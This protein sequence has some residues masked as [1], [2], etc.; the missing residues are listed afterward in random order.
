MAQTEYGQLQ[1]DDSNTPVGWG[2]LNIT[3]AQTIRF[4][5]TAPGMLHAVTINSPTTGGSITLYDNTTGSGTKIG[6]ITYAGA[7]LSNQA[8]CTALYDAVFTTGLT[9]VTGTTT[10]DFTVTYI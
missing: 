3:D 7:T 9:I 1:R 6:T 8:P 10:P 2:Y 5:K 4:V